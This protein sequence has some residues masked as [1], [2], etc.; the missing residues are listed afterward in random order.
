MAAPTTLGGEAPRHT[1]YLLANLS[2]DFVIGGRTVSKSGI[3]R[4]ADRETLRHIGTNQPRPFQVAFDPRDPDRFYYAVLNGIMRTTDG[5]ETWRVVTGWNMTEPKDV[6]VDPHRPDRIFIGLPDGVGVS[7]DGGD[8]W[9]YRDAGI[10]RK[11]TESLVVDRAVEGHLLAGTELG[12]Y[13]TTNAGH[14]WERVLETTM[15]VHDVEQCPADPSRFYAVTQADGAWTSDDGGKT[16]TRMP[17]IPTEHTL[18]HLS[19]D[20]NDPRRILIGGWGLGVRLS[21]DGGASW[22]DRGAGLPSPNIWSLSFD[23]DFPGRIYASP[24]EDA[25]HVSDDLGRTWKPLFFDGALVWEYQF[26]KEDR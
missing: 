6:V 10:R 9:A 13:R 7:E 5:G 3:F 21:E 14:I 24:Y 16:W 25:L 1:L 19:I 4:T 15:Q 23:P 20:R 26:V 2:K 17:G 11:F 12:I 18:H 22:T 8:T